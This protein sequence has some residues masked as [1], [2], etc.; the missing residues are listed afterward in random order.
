MKNSILTKTIR[1]DGD[2]D[3]DD[4]TRTSAQTKNALKKVLA[5]IEKD[6]VRI[7][8]EKD[9]SIMESDTRFRDWG[10]W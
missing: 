8:K 5:K 9:H 3:G 7:F 2:V 1:I 6:M 4:I 10:W